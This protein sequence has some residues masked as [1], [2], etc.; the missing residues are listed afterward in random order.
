MESERRD[1]TVREE[2]QRGRRD[3]EGGGAEGGE[4]EM[5]GQREREKRGVEEGQSRRRAGDEMVKEEGQ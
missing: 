1:E 4:A 2:G 5:E 3:R